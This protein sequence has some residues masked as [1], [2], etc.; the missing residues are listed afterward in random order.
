MW[1]SFDMTVYAYLY[2]YIGCIYFRVALIQKY[3][4][5]GIYMEVFRLQHKAQIYILHIELWCWAEMKFLCRY[6]NSKTVARLVMSYM[7]EHLYPTVY[8]VRSFNIS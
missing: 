7:R 8:V 5:M 4:Y 6:T 3:I 2:V 1:V